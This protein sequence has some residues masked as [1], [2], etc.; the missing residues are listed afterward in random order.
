MLYALKSKQHGNI[1]KLEMY[2]HDNIIEIH[3]DFCIS[4][5]TQYVLKA[6]N[7][8]DRTKIVD[9]M[10]YI[11][12]LRYVVNKNRQYNITTIKFIEIFKTAIF[13]VENIL[14]IISKDLDLILTI[15]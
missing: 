9:S 7:K 13:D 1:V 6:K 8:N 12:N 14:M 5:Y 4:N 2:R 3:I 10:E 15:G 11:S